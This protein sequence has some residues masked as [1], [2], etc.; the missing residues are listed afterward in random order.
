MGEN[1]RERAEVC[2][3]A[4]E[5]SEGDVA[6]IG[7]GWKEDTPEGWMR[8]EEKMVGEEGHVAELKPAESKKQGST[9]GSSKEDNLFQEA[10]NEWK[11][12]EMD[13]EINDQIQ[14]DCRPQLTEI[15]PNVP[16]REVAEGVL[17]RKAAQRTWKGVV[18]ENS[19]PEVLDAEQN[20]DNLPATGIKSIW[21][22]G[23][24]EGHQYSAEGVNKR[25]KE[26]Q[27]EESL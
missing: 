5:A 2:R 6:N 24:E 22:Q 12:G 9:E 20:K 17:I 23:K 26:V 19:R 11:Q 16:V 8:E 4:G 10:I 21:V 18:K 14:A 13:I 3:E 1:I 25:C 27:E 7:I 15:N